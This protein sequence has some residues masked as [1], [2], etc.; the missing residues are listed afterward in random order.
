[1]DD[2]A[3]QAKLQELDARRRSLEQQRAT[4]VRRRAIL[5]EQIAGFGP[6]LAPVHKITELEDEE[7][8]IR[9]VEAE[10]DA[11]MA[12]MEALRGSEPGRA[13][14]MGNVLGNLGLAYAALGDT[15]KAI[16]F[17]ERRL[18]IANE[19]GDRRGEGNAY[20]NLGLAHESLGHVETAKRFWQQALAIFEA[21][22]SPYAE[23][24]RGW[25]AGG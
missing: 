17:Y 6:N 16:G 19:I 25:L 13:S 18:V 23:R 10:I 4:H 22:K 2:Q 5:Q 1:M 3:R 7:R 14:R 24:V 9:R 11:I 15:G 21:I 8:A 12:E 20:A